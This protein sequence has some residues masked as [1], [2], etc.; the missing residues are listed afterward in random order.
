MMISDFLEEVYFD[1]LVQRD[2]IELKL[3]ISNVIEQYN[4]YVKPGQIKYVV[5]VKYLILDKKIR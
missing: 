4:K 1:N 3:D 2:V 5:P